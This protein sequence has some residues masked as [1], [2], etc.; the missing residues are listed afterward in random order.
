MKKVAIYARYSSDNQ[1]EE[2]I[3]AQIRAINEFCNRNN[4]QVVKT[5]TDE[6]KS[7]TSD[8]RPQFQQMIKDS[9]TKLFDAVIVHKLD[10]F[11]RDRYDSA[12]Y[13]RE[14]K[15]NKVKLIS[16][17]ENLDDSPES[18]ILESVLEGM[19]EYYSANL[20]REVM[21]GMKETA[22]QCKHTG[23]IPPLGYDINKDKSYV[24]NE[25]EADII[26]LIFNMYSSGETYGSIQDTLKS[27]G[28]KTKTGKDFSCSA[29]STILRNEKYKGTYVFNKTGQK[30]NG[31]RNVYLKSDEDIIKIENGIPK[32]VDENTWNIVNKRMDESNKSTQS[33]QRAKEPYLLTGLIQCGCCNGA[34]VGNRR[35]S[36][37][38]KQKYVTYECNTRKRTKGCNAKAINKDFIENLVI[39]FLDNN[40]LTYSNI[41]EIATLVLEGLKNINKGI[42][43]ALANYKKSLNQTNKE[44]ENIINAIA[45]GMF[46]PSMK[47]KMDLLEA[48]KAD[49]ILK[50]TS[51]EQQL[52]VTVIPTKKTIIDYLESNK[53]IK[54]KPLNQQKAIIQRFIEKIIVY[55]DK[56]EIISIVDTNNGG[57]GNRTPVRKPINRG[58]YHHSHCF[59][60]PSM[61]RPE[62][63]CS[64][65]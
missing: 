43:G 12:F 64:L 51:Y 45:A 52:Q 23:G 44:T 55:P 41:D 22:Y 60:I 33:A 32:I 11:S 8:N 48:K 4:Y 61:N 3:E 58:L 38:N 54:N 24:I 20:S 34:M 36:G 35:F 57:E 16:V 14:L 47:E 18:I 7:A 50:I 10:R 63:G 28:Y 21:K 49:L 29:L 2:S 9:S 31:K 1:R 62:T 25:H 37:R 6:A 5:Y 65:W 19:A 26:R 15:K 30:Q 46:H 40:L 17:L 27:K 59:N 56:V 13:K 39:E 42:P 53:D